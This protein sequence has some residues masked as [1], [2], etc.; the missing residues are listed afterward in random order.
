MLGRQDNL[1]HLICAKAAQ[2][3][4]KWVHCMVETIDSHI[5]F[6]YDHYF[7]S[8]VFCFDSSVITSTDPPNKPLQHFEVPHNFRAIIKPIVAIQVAFQVCK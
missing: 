3:G 1:K 2:T 7:V 8:C 4:L 5:V 6:I